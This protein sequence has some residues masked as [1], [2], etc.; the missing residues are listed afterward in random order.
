MSQHCKFCPRP[1]THAVD[2]VRFLT[3]A[4]W[5]DA[6]SAVC[7]HHVER[8]T[9]LRLERHPDNTIIISLLKVKA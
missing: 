2:D 9:H 5:T 6:F 1:A 3:G 7:E 8:E 4:G